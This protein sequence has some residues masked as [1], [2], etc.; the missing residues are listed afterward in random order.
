MNSHSGRGSAPWSRVWRGG[1]ACALLALLTSG[2]F[3]LALKSGSIAVSWGELWRGLFVEYN[4]RVAAVYD[5]RFPR[6]VVALL[7]GAML[8]ASGL[9]LQAALRNPLADPGIIGI[10]G[11]AAFTAALVGAF[12]PMLYFSK[13]LFAFIG[14]ILSFLLIYRLAW[15]GSLDP[16]RIILV[17]VAVSATCAGLSAALFGAGA[18]PLISGL[19][20]RSWGDVRQLSLYAATGILAALL[21]APACNYLAL[22]DRTARGLG[23]NADLLRGVVSA[24][25]VMLASAA[26]AIIGVVGFLALIAPHMARRFV[27]SDHRILTPFC[28]LL[29]AFV[30]LA[31]DTLGRLVAAPAEIPASV[32]MNV[33]GGP[34]F[35]ILLQRGERIGRS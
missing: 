22:E 20:Q 11:G 2:L 27:G 34:F 6:V 9:F 33:V 12:F 19:V 31:A 35:I 4:P 16:V 18:N 30:L 23:I 7:A 8:A 28:L 15:K 26:T 1:A 29:G 3:L 13:P 17:G 21:L 14:G 32:L 25:A 10:A 24:V 5:L